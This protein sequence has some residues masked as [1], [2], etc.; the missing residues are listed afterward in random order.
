LAEYPL[1]CRDDLKEKRSAAAH[2][3][4]RNKQR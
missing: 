3:L 1:E 2:F 4:Q